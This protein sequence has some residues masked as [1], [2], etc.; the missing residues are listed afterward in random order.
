MS[1]QSL[2]S[3]TGAAS[4]SQIGTTSS[5]VI[6]KDAFLQILVA[7]LKYQDPMDPMKADQFMTQLAQL[8]QVEQLQNISDSLDIMKAAKE[9][10]DISKWFSAIGKKMGVDDKIMSKGDQVSLT[11]AGDFDQVVL[12]LTDNATGLTSTVTFNKGD[13][14]TYTYQ[15]DS[16]VTATAIAIKN[17][18]Q[19]GCTTGLY[20]TIAGVQLGDSGIVLVA[21]SGETYTTDKV[22]QIKE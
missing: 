11:P 3:S 4:S 7:Q 6:N 9:N 14:L 21:G 16:S 1:I 20:R 18:T 22:K 17:G 8:T 2:T 19:I 5:G 15:G 13:A 12:G 10:G